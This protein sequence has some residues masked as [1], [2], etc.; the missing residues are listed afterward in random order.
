[1]EF[2]ATYLQLHPLPENFQPVSPVGTPIA[3]IVSYPLR[4][5]IFNWMLPIDEGGDGTTDVLSFWFT[6]TTTR[7]LYGHMKYCLFLFGGYKGLWL[8]HTM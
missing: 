5:L 2:L 1:M 3:G 8:K 6:K 7:Y 4:H